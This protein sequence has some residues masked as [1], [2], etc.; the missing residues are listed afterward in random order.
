MER[1]SEHLRNNLLGFYVI[2]DITLRSIS[3]PLRNN[4]IEEYKI[5]HTPF[6]KPCT[7]EV[8]RAS[9]N[10]GYVNASSIDR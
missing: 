4:A 2:S 10:D 5:I 1:S 7:G 9:C 8:T 6:E 3:A